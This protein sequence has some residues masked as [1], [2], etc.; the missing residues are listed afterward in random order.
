MSA[1]G[2]SAAAADAHYAILNEWVRESTGTEYRQPTPPID[3]ECFEDI[4]T[5][6]P[7]RS[8]PLLPDALPH[9][10]LTSPCHS[11]SPQDLTLASA[12]GEKIAFADKLRAELKSTKVLC[13]V[14]KERLTTEKKEN[15][16][17]KYAFSQLRKRL[18]NTETWM[19]QVLGHA[20]TSQYHIPTSSD[21]KK[22]KKA[23]CPSK[24]GKSPQNA[25]KQKKAHCPQ[26]P[27]KSPQNHS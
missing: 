13:D 12:L 20:R 6:E 4:S 18:Q 1:D 27:V 15:Q 23:D 22:L 14:L 19:G 3:R 11:D 16:K 8:D 7:M 5:G 9:P 21:E 10:L 24:P 2:P 26:K 25:K 17:L